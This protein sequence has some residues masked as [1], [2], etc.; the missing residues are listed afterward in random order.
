MSL[1]GL[2]DY[3]RPLHGFKYEI[4][5]P[6][7]NSGSF[8]VASS[9]LEISSTKTGRPDFLLEMVRGVSP[10]MPPK[11]YAVLD[12]RVRAVHPAE[13]ALAL[14]RKEHPNATV[15]PPAFRSGFLRLQPTANTA[16]MPEELLQPIALAASGLGI[17][18]FVMRLSPA[19]GA[20]IEGA[21]KGEVLG[22]L[23]W[24][25]MEM[26]GVAPRV[27]VR[28]TFDPGDLLNALAEAA[29]KRTA[30][31]LTRDQL[32]GFFERDLGKL[33]LRLDSA[34]EDAFRRDFVEAMADWVRVRYGEFVASQQ[35]PVEFSISLRMQEATGGQVSWDLSKPLAAPRAMIASLDPFD[36]ARQ[37]VKSEGIS[38]FLKQTVVPPLSTGTKR[39]HIAAN[40][41]FLRAGVLSLGVHVSAP[42]KPPHRM[43][44]IHETLEFVTPADSGVVTLK[45]SAA[46]PFAYEYST[47][48]VAEQ[49]GGI[50]RLE[51]DPRNHEGP[52]LDLGVDDFPLK[53]V[54]VEAATA[55]LELGTISG[56]CE[57][58]A[59]EGPFERRFELT[60]SHPAVGIGVPKDATLAPIRIAAAEHEGA[61]IL[62]LTLEP[63]QSAQL[64]LTSFPEFGP[65]RV[66]IECRFDEASS[67]FLAVDVVAEG[68][69]ESLEA[70]Q[71]FA[72]TPAT[73]VKEWAYLAESPFYAGYR[74]RIHA[75]SGDSTSP[76]SDVQS[77]AAPLRLKASAASSPRDHFCDDERTAN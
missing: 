26:E 67:A 11:P 9:Q 1:L 19:A 46:E 61:R 74:Y 60:P 52:T 13:P 71:T 66:K 58:Q 30:P 3:Q 50:G 69:E 73:P 38:S 51:N 8:V 49:A 55:L 43:Q 7:E 35:R 2:P 77:P 64:D 23:A 44:A 28:V 42:P 36:A 6:F 5:Y 20:I 32:E 45:M 63:G 18:R 47:W 34:L 54:T 10:A 31:V 48:A 22:L 40:L 53:F 72:L 24:A 15:G 75:I 21:L 16:D 41:P 39:V 4:Y 70:V 25:E 17:A 65:H 33:P 57:G 12:F 27:P 29:G 59:K 37:L 56:V 14:V 76:W 62:R 68:R